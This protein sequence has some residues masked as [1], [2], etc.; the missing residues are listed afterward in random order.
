MDQAIQKQA[1][2]MALLGSFWH[3]VSGLSALTGAGAD[4]DQVLQDTRWR[5]P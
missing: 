5:Y 2:A 3:P 4:A 1:V